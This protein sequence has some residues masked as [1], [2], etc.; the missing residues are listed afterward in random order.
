MKDY[1]FSEEDRNFVIAHWP[2]GMRLERTGHISDFGVWLAAQ[3]ELGFHDETLDDTVLITSDTIRVWIHGIGSLRESTLPYF[4][5]LQEYIE[6]T[7][8]AQPQSGDRPFPE[9]S[10]ISDATAAYF[11]WCGAAILLK[12]RAFCKFLSGSSLLNGI[13]TN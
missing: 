11:A 6:T 8:F 7:G 5:R 3:H 4:N 1:Q 12:N 13:C 10:P 9:M 2:S